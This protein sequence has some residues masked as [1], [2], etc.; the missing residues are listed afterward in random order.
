V[1]YAEVPEAYAEV[2]EAYAEV[3]E[4][5]AEVPEAYAEVPV[6][7]AEVP[8]VYAEVPMAYARPSGNTGITKISP[9]GLQ[10]YRAGDMTVFVF[11][12]IESVP[13]DTFRSGTLSFASLTQQILFYNTPLNFC[14][15]LVR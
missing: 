10:N 12:N 9:A 2:P 4:A 15:C 11:Y 7:Y 1:V 5:Y 3:P 6:V 13:K 8:V 14:K